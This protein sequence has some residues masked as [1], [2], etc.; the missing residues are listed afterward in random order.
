MAGLGRGLS[1]LLSQSAEKSARNADGKSTRVNRLL[2]RSLAH[3]QGQDEYDE[4]APSALNTQ[5]HLPQE[6]VK[7][8]A[9]QDAIKSA[10]AQEE[11]SNSSEKMHE[12]AKE[13]FNAADDIAKGS[14][15]KAKKSLKQGKDKHKSNLK[16]ERKDNKNNAPEKVGSFGAEELA[17][18]MD[19]QDAS[20]STSSSIT[21][22]SMNN[23]VHDLSIDKLRPSQY[24]PRTN[25]DEKAILELSKSI[26]T[27]GLLEPLLVKKVGGD[28]YEIICG[29]RRFRA[30][31]A[32]KLESVPCL[33]RDVSDDKGYAIALIENL[34]REDLN[35]VEMAIAI[36]QMMQ[37][38]NMTQDDVAKNIGKSRSTVANLLRV[39]KL[40]DEPL[41][42][43][44]ANKI[45]LGHAKLLLSLSGSH[46]VEA[47]RTIIKKALS[48]RGTEA[49]IKELQQ[50]QDKKNRASH[51]DKEKSKKS[52]DLYLELLSK[53]EKSVSDRLGGCKAK[54]KHQHDGK[55]SLVLSYSSQDELSKIIKALGLSVVSSQ[56]GDVIATDDK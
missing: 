23:V 35:P 53:L 2:Q 30:A 34:Q 44:R 29:E 21:V 9:A 41:A 39:L 16:S 24:Q 56:D 15:S 55:G 6:A 17:A 45:D 36:D 48:V 13:S 22:E 25:F 43:L 46:Q 33:I 42:C 28:I 20:L 19:A 7:S 50:K 49:Y 40:E 31:K 18:T 12:A 5:K 4:I 47:C 26:A 1:A 3:A 37:E 32:A 11:P 14:K 51:S 38:C 10:T 54:F 52:E 8:T 27:H